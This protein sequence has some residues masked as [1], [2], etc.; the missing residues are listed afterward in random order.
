MEDI[1]VTE[2]QFNKYQK[3]GGWLL[4]FLLLC[5]FNIGYSIN[6]WMQ[7]ISLFNQIPDTSIYN[8]NLLIV[9]THLEGLY[10]VV[11]ISYI[12]F[13]IIKRKPSK[14]LRNVIIV[15]SIGAIIIAIVFGV[16]AQDL[17]IAAN[18]VETFNGQVVY[19]VL[20]KLIFSLIWG[21]YVMR[22]IR[23]KVYSGEIEEPTIYKSREL[24]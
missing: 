4:I 17:M 10:A 8:L 19:S 5:G 15:F 23:V 13:S 7:A 14:Y 20:S 12:V 18:N 9:F 11:L 16:L 21:T 2:T 24:S 3:L 6:Q 22:S 1:R